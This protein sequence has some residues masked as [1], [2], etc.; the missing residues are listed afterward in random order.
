[1]ATA[2]FFLDFLFRFFA[3]LISQQV[4]EIRSAVEEPLEEAVSVVYDVLSVVQIS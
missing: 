3:R 2:I 4:Y 1:M